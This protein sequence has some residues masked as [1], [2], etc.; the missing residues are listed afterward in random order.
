MPGS[1]LDLW[2]SCAV[3]SQAFPFSLVLFGLNLLGYIMH[4]AWC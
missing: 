4:L 3:L 2:V 1:L